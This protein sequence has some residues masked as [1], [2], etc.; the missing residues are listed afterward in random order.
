MKRCS[1]YQSYPDTALVSLLKLGD[2]DAFTEIYERHVAALYRHAYK[3]LQDADIC[4]DLVQEVFLTMW[5]KREALQVSG[6]LAAY[7]HRAVRNRALDVISHG[8][9]ADKYI[10]S[11]REFANRGLWTV[12]EALREKELLAIIEAE[13]AKLPPRMRQIYE[14]N[15][16]HDLSYREI[17]EQL[18]ISEKTVKKQVHNALRVIRLKLSSLL[19]LLLGLLFF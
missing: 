15:R 17:G 4:N 1:P 9:V 10:D 8:Q 6:A 7:L 14:L 11:I 13:K 19:S 12:D 5:E 18:A 16:E 3:V 2:H